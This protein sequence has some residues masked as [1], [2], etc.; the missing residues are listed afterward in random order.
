MFKKLGALALTA[1]A[2]FCAVP[3]EASTY[4]PWT[5][6]AF[7][8][9]GQ[10]VVS[11]PCRGIS[12]GN[13]RYRVEWADGKSDIFTYL[14]NSVY[15][16]TRGGIWAS[17]TTRYDGYSILTLHSYSSGVEFSVLVN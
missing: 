3:A 9:P 1:G 10:S 5:T 6:C 15:R 7:Q 17:R 13:Q 8:R 16:D 2:L 11:M 14:G 12:L 4:T